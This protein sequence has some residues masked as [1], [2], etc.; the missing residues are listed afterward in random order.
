[1][2]NWWDT[3][4][5]ETR[6]TL[7]RTNYAASLDTKQRILDAALDQFHLRG[8]NGTSVQDEAGTGKEDSF[9]G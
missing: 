1:M 2:A 4:R 9:G 7:A 6:I 8:Y 5:P 3:G